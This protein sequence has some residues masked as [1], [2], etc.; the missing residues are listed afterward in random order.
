MY[1]TKTTVNTKAKLRGTDDVC[2]GDAARGKQTA[3]R[4]H[5]QS[6]SVVYQ[7][8]TLRRERKVILYYRLS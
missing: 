1:H 6:R 8:V 4:E 7:N 3:V 5:P 2:G